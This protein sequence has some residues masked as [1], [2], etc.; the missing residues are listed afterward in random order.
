[1]RNCYKELPEGYKESIVIDA[2][3]KKTG[4]I[5]NVGALLI[6]AIVAFITINLKFIR[7]NF[8]IDY[9]FFLAMI[10]GFVGFI[11]YIVIHELTH[12]VAYKLLTKEKLTFG[13]SWSC[14]YCGVP[15]VFVKRNAAVI[16]CLA[17]FVIYNILFIILICVLPSNIITF[18]I[19]II[20]AYHNGGC[21]GDL[22]LSLLLL[23]KYDKNTLIKDTGA[24]QEI[25]T[26]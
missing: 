10:I 23:V 17:P 21:I 11:I 12:G 19:V 4:I 6:M 26:K 1:M 18:A 22:Y 20:F 3:D 7:L 15:N 9:K 5:L 25:Y 16:A 24:K 2:K 13:L 14:A 8:D